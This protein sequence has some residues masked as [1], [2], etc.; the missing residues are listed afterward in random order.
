MEH[1]LSLVSN[2][3]M[4]EPGQ[5][6]PPHNLLIPALS[7]M[8]PQSLNTTYVRTYAVVSGPLLPCHEA[9]NTTQLRNMLVGEFTDDGILYTSHPKHFDCVI[10]PRNSKA[11]ALCNAN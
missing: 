8:T 1:Q 10:K 7:F 2:L 4:V 11:V 6:I 5:S 3:P 9:G